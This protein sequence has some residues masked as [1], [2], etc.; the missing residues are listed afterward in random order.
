MAG[1]WLLPFTNG[2]S[3]GY[4]SADTEGEAIHRKH[5]RLRYLG[6]EA[7]F[8]RGLNGV[9]AH[10]GVECGLYVFTLPAGRILLCLLLV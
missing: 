3:F 2:C 10:R 4:G 9:L 6:S 7:F 5:L 1:P 8:F